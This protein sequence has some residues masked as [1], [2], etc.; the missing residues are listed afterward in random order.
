MS[1]HNTAVANYYSMA[2]KEV[3]PLIPAP[4]AKIL[5]IGCGAGATLA[6]LKHQG[7]CHIAYGVELMPTPAQEAAKV[8]DN[9]WVDN[10][11]TFTPPIAS[12]SLDV[13]LCLD[14]LEHLVDP[15]AVVKKLT[16]LLK[17]N[18]VLI[19]SI[20]NI[21]HHSV[22]RQII[23]NGDFTY[24]D[25]GILDRTHLRFFTRK[26]ILQLAECS[27]LNVDLVQNLHGLKLRHWWKPK[28]AIKMLLNKI[29]PHFFAIQYLVRARKVS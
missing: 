8:C 19:A 17:K 9:L 1:Q 15:W 26:T 11:E 10:I 25:W 29:F 18:G 22:L 3:A 28:R 27:G 23:F 14:V 2:R 20:P 16:P 7:L 6:Y 4:K 13:I 5:E 24:E 12:N 21:R